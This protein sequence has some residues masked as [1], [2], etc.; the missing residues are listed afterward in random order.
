LLLSEKG[1]TNW[2]GNLP[3]PLS[4]FVGRE[5]E[6]EAVRWLLTEHRLLTLTG[7]GGCGKTRLALTCA[8]QLAPLFDGRTWFVDL[9]SL[10]DQTL[11]PRAIAA[12]LHIREEPGA[13]PLATLVATLAP[14]Q[15]LL[16]LDNCEHV[17]GACAQLANALLRRC[18]G[19]RILATSREALGVSGEVVWTVPSLSFPASAVALSG[20]RL[21]SDALCFE[22]MRLFIERARSVDPQFSADPQALPV[23]A[24]ICRRLD[25][26]P[27]AIELAAARVRV[28]S[29]QQIA[30]RLDDC[31][32]L[33]TAGTRTAPAR[34]RTLAATLDWSYG[35]L[36]QNEQAVLRRL[37]VF[38]G[39]WSLEAAEAVCAG[40][41]VA[42]SEVLDLLSNL[43]HK[44]L[45]VMVRHGDESRYRLLETVRQY[46]RRQLIGAGEQTRVEHRHLAFFA[47][48]IDRAASLLTGAEQHVWFE[49]LELDLDNLR[50]AMDRSIQ[51]ADVTGDIDA[52]VRAL[53]LPADLERFWSPR[54]YCG[55]GAERLARALALPGAQTAGAAIARA[56]ALNAAGVLSW[57]Q[58]RYPEAQ[59]LIEEA[60][61]IG[62]MTQDRMTILTSLRNLGTLAV[63]RRDI[64][65]GSKLLERGLVLGRAAGVEA[66]H[67]V[68]WIVAVQGSAAYIEGDHERA[69]PLFEESVVL[70]REHGDANFL[71]LVLRRLGQIALRRGVDKQAGQLL[72]ESLEL[73]G[74]VGSPAGIAACISALAGVLLIQCRPVDAAV[75]L[76]VVASVLAETAAHLTAADQDLLKD[77][78]AQVCGRLDSQA[79][80][81]AW[82]KGRAVQF[83]AAVAYTTALVAAPALVR[84]CLTDREREVA[85]LVAQ[86]QSNRQI[87][88]TLTVE[89]KTVEAHLT[90]ILQKLGASSRVQ[91]ATWVVERGLVPPQWPS[92]P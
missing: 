24:E 68:A 21:S 16:V 69:A 5:R 7:A 43:V 4:S 67:P 31:V 57:F 44:S 48:F 87:A 89:V 47:R 18:P 82:K 52:V 46:A 70:F 12:P 33:L 14:H 53:R 78:Q 42:V 1:M 91:I 54:G 55:E 88:Q 75:L 76:G 11:V 66:R 19:L 29:V 63:L 28:L 15:T 86:G 64:V 34:Q 83:R 73:N 77:L 62:E 84:H 27:L 79:F 8:E 58:S 6:V 74:Q 9:S 17:V 22:A 36:S 61:A 10:A 92:S 41:A 85:A 37:S 26:M 20:S 40:E 80:H 25:G 51:V 3:I 65:A 50:A 72:R 23:I 90:H 30:A 71:A 60:L 59:R 35:L 45:I 56:H 39:G 38:G 32:R 81:A 2:T 49:R 13:P